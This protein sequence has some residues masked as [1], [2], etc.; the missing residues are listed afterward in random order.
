MTTI[1]IDKIFNAYLKEYVANLKSHK[2]TTIRA[3]NLDGFVYFFTPHILIK[4]PESW[5]P[6]KIECQDYKNLVAPL[7]RQF[8]SD[9]SLH[10]EGKSFNNDTQ[11]YIFKKDDSEIFVDMKM[12]DNWVKVE[13]CE[14]HGTNSKEPVYIINRDTCIGLVMPIY[15]RG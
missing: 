15:V 14:F 2:A 12:L 4:V 13:E 10:L 6:F 9:T 8:Y 1:K 7:D 11:V 3:T 5:V